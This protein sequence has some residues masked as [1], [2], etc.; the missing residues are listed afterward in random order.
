VTGIGAR[1]PSLRRPALLLPV[2]AVAG[3][4]AVATFGVSWAWWCALGV[5]ASLAVSGSP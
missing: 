2:L 4:G 5:V 3:L 1:R